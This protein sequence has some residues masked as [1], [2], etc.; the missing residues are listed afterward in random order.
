MNRNHF[1]IKDNNKNLHVLPLR[2]L[3]FLLPARYF[4]HFLCCLGSNKKYNTTTV[5]DNLDIIYN[6][7]LMNTRVGVLR[8]TRYR[9]IVA[10]LIYDM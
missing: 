8:R 2:L 4:W 7:Y 5:L 6:M 9:T 1:E 10:I 3:R